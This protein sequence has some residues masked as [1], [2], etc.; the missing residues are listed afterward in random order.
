V[1]GEDKLHVSI[2]GERGHGEWVRAESV[3]S[4]AE[5]SDECVLTRR[6]L[7]SGRCFNG[8]FEGTSIGEDLNGCRET[9]TVIDGAEVTEEPGD[10]VDRSGRSEE[11]PETVGERE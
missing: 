8:Q 2:G 5:E 4:R 1:D 6:P 11:V 7:E 3:D 9:K 10:E